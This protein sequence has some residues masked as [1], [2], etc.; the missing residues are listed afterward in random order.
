VTEFQYH[1]DLDVVEIEGANEELADPTDVVARN[2]KLD[3]VYGDLQDKAARLTRLE[4]TVES[5]ALDIQRDNVN[6]LL[7]AVEHGTQMSPGDVR[8]TV[9]SDQWASLEGDADDRDP[10]RSDGSDSGSVKD[11]IAAMAASG[12]QAATDGGPRDEQ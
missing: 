1:D 4:A 11:V 5:K 12:E 7:A 9:H 10:E 3:E 6:A 8:E 2:G